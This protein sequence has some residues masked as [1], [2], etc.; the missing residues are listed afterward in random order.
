ME[1]KTNYRVKN[2]GVARGRTGGTIVPPLAK[3]YLYK[4]MQYIY[5]NPVYL[6]K[7]IF[8]LWEFS[9]VSN[10]ESIV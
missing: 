6:K 5:K 7:M 3:F 1:L 2:T 4:Y 9:Q 10:N 8:Y